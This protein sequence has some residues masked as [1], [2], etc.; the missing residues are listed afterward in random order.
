MSTARPVSRSSV[1][2]AALVSVPSAVGREMSLSL[3]LLA[4]GGVAMI[5][6]HLFLGTPRYGAYLLF[7]LFH[8]FLSCLAGHRHGLLLHR[9]SPPTTTGRR[10]RFLPPL[11]PAAE[12]LGLTLLVGTGGALLGTPLAGAQLAIAELTRGLFAGLALGLLSTASYLGGLRAGLA[13]GSGLDATMVPALPLVAGI[14]W[15]ALPPPFSL[16]GL[17]SPLVALE[18]PVGILKAAGG[19]GEAMASHPLISR[20]LGGEQGILL[21]MA[22]VMVLALYLAVFTVDY[23]PLP[24]LRRPRGAAAPTLLLLVVLAGLMVGAV[25]L[26]FNASH[27]ADP[28]LYPAQVIMAYGGFALLVVG[29]WAASPGGEPL[30]R[31]ELGRGLLLA[32][33]FLSPSPVLARVPA[34]ELL[35]YL[36]TALALFLLAQLT[37]WLS[38]RRL[39]TLVAVGMVA[40]LALLLLLSNA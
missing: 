40:Y 5:L 29:A 31:G 15:Y 7:I 2:T 38:R 14:T 22:P 9:L 10:L 35:P 23:E 18:A 20:A 25:N 37:A 21:A 33:L 17:A 16:A 3:A 12:A 39:T 19:V 6:A 27:P 4:G 11:R 1:G 8:P 28:R 32:L 13:G 24:A 26:P 34:A 30:P 36:G